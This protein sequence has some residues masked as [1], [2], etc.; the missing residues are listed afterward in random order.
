[1]SL[2]FLLLICIILL[3]LV[4]IK[5]IAVKIEISDTLFEL[6]KFIASKFICIADYRG[7]DNFIYMILH[8]NTYNAL[9]SII[10]SQ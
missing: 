9:Q 3:G 4:E 2:P 10:H 6:S 5:N 1:M 7:I 8:K